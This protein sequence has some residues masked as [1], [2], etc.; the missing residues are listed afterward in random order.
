MF[1]P[2]LQSHLQEFGPILGAI[3]NHS[4]LGIFVF[5]VFVG[6]LIPIPEAV[7]LLLIG[8]VAKANGINPWLAIVVSGVGAIVGDNILYRLSFFGNKYVERFNKKMRSHK[9]IQY[10]H[11][12]TENIGSTIFFLRF[13]A[14]VRFFGPVISGTLG[15]KWKKF[16]TYNALATILH[17]ALFILL[18]FY[19][20]RRI[21]ALITEIEIVHNILLFSSVLIVGLLVRIFTKTK[22]NP[23]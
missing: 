6:Y 4:Y 14:G 10:E 17:A 22:K 12:V 18:A 7:L 5:S 21:V 3:K 13:I 11:L 8:F 15:I 2:H 1:Y 9:L 20:R 19:T 23:S 16:F